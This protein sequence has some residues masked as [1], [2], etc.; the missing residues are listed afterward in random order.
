MDILVLRNFCLSK[1]FAYEDFPFDDTT[2]VF[3][4]FDKMFALVSLDTI[5][6]QISLKCDPQFA[7]QLRE[8]HEFIRP[9]YHMNK[10]Y[11]IT[12]ELLPKV[13]DSFIFDLINHSYSEVIKKLPKKYQKQVLQARDE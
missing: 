2:L 9:G 5:P 10:K 6:L 7:V 13:A 11:W 4:V 3:K 8:E 12:V 1:P